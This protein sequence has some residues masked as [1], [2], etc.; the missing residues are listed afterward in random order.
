M[1][2]YSNHSKNFKTMAFDDLR[3]RLAK[4]KNTT[5]TFSKDFVSQTVTMEGINAKGEVLH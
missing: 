1:Y 3:V 4:V 2:T 5:F